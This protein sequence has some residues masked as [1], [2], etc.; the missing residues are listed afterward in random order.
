MEIPGPA[1]LSMSAANLGRIQP[2]ISAQEPLRATE[3]GCSSGGGVALPTPHPLRPGEAGAAIRGDPDS[4]LRTQGDPG[5][6]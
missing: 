2:R 4:P 6:H 5:A 1:D 3:S